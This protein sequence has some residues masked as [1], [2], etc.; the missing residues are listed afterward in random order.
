[1][2]N[3]GGATPV[4]VC[5]GSHSYIRTQRYDRY[6]TPLHLLAQSVD[7]YF[8]KSTAINSV[9]GTISRPADYGRENGV[10]SHASTGASEST[11]AAL[12]TAF[13][14]YVLLQPLRSSFSFYSYSRKKY[15]V[16]AYSS[17]YEKPKIQA[18]GT[19]SSNFSDEARPGGHGE[20]CRFATLTGVHQGAHICPA[21]FWLG[22][23]VRS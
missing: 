17:Q 20:C 10:I 5:T 7:D 21:N 11:R 14:E 6:F 13:W 22:G 19:T 1:M 15:Q 18:P 16:L 4:S 2:R 9:P 23:N 3:A 12:C 8:T